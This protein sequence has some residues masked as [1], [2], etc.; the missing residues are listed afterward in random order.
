MTP[1]LTSEG[2]VLS[3]ADMKVSRRG[4]LQVEETVGRKGPITWRCVAYLIKQRK[5]RYA[6][7]GGLAHIL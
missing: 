2:R 3:W 1:E 7:E 5:M 6:V 4:Y